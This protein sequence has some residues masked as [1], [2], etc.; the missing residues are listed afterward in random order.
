MDD[1]NGR[2]RRAAG[3]PALDNN[4]PNGTYSWTTMAERLQ[5]AGISW[6]CYQQADNYGTNVLEFFSQFINA[7]TSS[8]CTRTPSA[9]A[10][11]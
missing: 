7:P 8:A 2:S 6:K 1:R 5:N 10:R 9:S 11:S 3:G 4:A